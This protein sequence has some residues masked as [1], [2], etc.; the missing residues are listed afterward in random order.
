M[1]HWEHLDAIEPQ[2][3]QFWGATPTTRPELETLASDYTRYLESLSRCGFAIVAW[4]TA[5]VLPVLHSGHAASWCLPE[6]L[7]GFAARGTSVAA[8]PVNFWR[9]G[10]LLRI[11]QLVDREQERRA[12]EPSRSAG[13]RYG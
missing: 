5:H 7:Q 3:V 8:R 12:S 1:Q 4:R 9:D 10:W 11:A 2:E 13:S 6:H